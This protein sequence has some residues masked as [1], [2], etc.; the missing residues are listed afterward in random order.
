MAHW[1]GVF[2]GEVSEI[3]RY[4]YLGS[5]I[6]FKSKNFTLLGH[7]KETIFDLIAYITHVPITAKHFFLFR[8]VCWSFI[9]V[10]WFLLWKLLENSRR[11]RRREIKRLLQDRIP[12]KIS[13]K[14]NCCLRH[15]IYFHTKHHNIYK[16]NLDWWNASILLETV[17]KKHP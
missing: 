17:Y 7:E 1:Q 13:T 15:N 12:P 14:C 11:V 2:G 3:S 10:L 4:I 5:F 8:M 6:L 9:M 16:Y